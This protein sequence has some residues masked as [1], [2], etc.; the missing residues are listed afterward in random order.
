MKLEVKLQ[1]KEWYHDVPWYDRKASMSWHSDDWSF[2]ESWCDDVNS[3][4]PVQSVELVYPTCHPVGC[5]SL[6]REAVL[7]CTCLDYLRL[8]GALHI[9]RTS[10]ST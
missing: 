4:Q 5:A 1:W 2:D 6:L 10:V 9:F 3:S 8:E 7:Y